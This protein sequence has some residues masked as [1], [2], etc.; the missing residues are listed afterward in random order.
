MAVDRGVDQTGG[1]GVDAHADRSQVAG[2]GQGHPNHAA[3]RCRVRS[4]PDLAIERGDRGDVDDGPTLT[5]LHRLGRA[6][7]SGGDADAI[8][9][10]DE[11][12]RDHLL[13]RVEVGRRV[14]GAALA[15]GALRPADAGRVHQNP[16]WPHALGHLDG[17]D[18][19]I[20]VGD[21]D[22]AERTADLAG[23]LVALVFLQVGDD[24]LRTPGGEEAG[25]G[26][27]DPRRPTGHD[28][29]CSID[30]HGPRP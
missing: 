12:D 15:D 13:E 11:V 17:I 3:L 19:V 30:V 24:H 23:E 18:D 22:L 4:L 14:V 29:A 20:G 27:P 10:A 26:G 9:A 25:R 8:E 6:H 16:Q 5:E 1:D 2:D 21:V 7:R 28:C